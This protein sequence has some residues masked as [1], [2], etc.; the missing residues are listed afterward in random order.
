MNMA[1]RVSKT[2]SSW[3]VPLEPV[4]FSRNAMSSRMARVLSLPKSKYDFS[5][6]WMG[7]RKLSWSCQ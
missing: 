3:V 6:A 1:K 2:S 4:S 5:R 7:E